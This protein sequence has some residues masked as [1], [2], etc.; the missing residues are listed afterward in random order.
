[1]PPVCRSHP[2]QANRRS[3]NCATDQ[4]TP[5]VLGKPPSCLLD[6]GG[7]PQID[8]QTLR[9]GR[10]DAKRATPLPAAL[11]DRGRPPDRMMM[12]AEICVGEL[13]REMKL[14]KGRHDGKGRK[15]RSHGAIVKLADLSAGHVL[16]AVRVTCASPWSLADRSAVQ[17]FQSE[18]VPLEA[19]PQGGGRSRPRPRR[20]CS[21]DLQS[22]SGAP[23][24][25]RAWSS[26]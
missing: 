2:A 7:G 9:I 16:C 22:F 19:W 3:T 20:Q 6:F 10:S 26:R 21:R 18:H 1:V 13:L 17:S 14:R 15:E 24:S 23:R 4:Q 5:F 25:Y 12:R 11:V 8:G